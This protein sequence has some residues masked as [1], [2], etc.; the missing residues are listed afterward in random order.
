M[1][2]TILLTLHAHPIQ[3]TVRR[4]NNQEISI[5]K[6]THRPYIASRII[7]STSVLAE[8]SLDLGARP[9]NQE[10][11]RL[12][13]LR[14]EGLDRVQQRH[15]SKSNGKCS[16]C[17]RVR[18]ERGMSRNPRMGAKESCM[19]CSHPTTHS[20]LSHG[21]TY[22]QEERIFFSLQGLRRVVNQL[23]IVLVFLKR[24]FIR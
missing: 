19:H 12:M 16:R 9:P 6:F 20:N 13:I 24:A 14:V 18:I 8:Q 21:K 11:Q 10:A 3:H 15:C 1:E 4:R 23:I 22:R 2:R 7:Y 5:F 17:Q